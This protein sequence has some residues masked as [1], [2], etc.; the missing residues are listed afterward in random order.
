MEKERQI[1]DNDLRSDFL[2]MI[3][4]E[5]LVRTAKKY[6]QTI[7]TPTVARHH[8]AEA[9]SSLERLDVKTFLP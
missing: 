9:N 8:G 7:S 5:I 4:F 6:T 1:W 2:D 3:L